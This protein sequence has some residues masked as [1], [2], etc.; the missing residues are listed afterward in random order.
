MNASEQQDKS[1]LHELAFNDED[2]RVSVAAL[3]K[4]NNFDLWWKMAEIAKDQRV[5]KHAKQK[6]EAALLGEIDIGLSESQKISFLKECNNVAL[7][8]ML[9]QKGAI[10]EANTLLML[11]VLKRINR[12]QTTLRYLNKSGNSELQ[13]A[14]FEDVREESDLNKVIK[15]A[16]NPELVEKAQ[17][18]L[19]A[20][21]AEKQKPVELNKQVKL[22]LAKLLALLDEPDF[23]KFSHQREGLAEAYD[24]LAEQFSILGQEQ[25][26][27]YNEKFQNLQQ[28]LDKKQSAL[29]EKWQVQQ[30]VERTSQALSDAKSTCRAVLDKVAEAL[31]KDASSITLG[32]LESFNQDI[33]LAEQKLNAMLSE[34]LTEQEFR[35]I[36]ALIND[37][38]QSRSS[39]DA[40][41]ALQQAISQANTM[42]EQF[43]ALPLP[44]DASQI[45]AAYEYLDEV[46]DR[47]KALS[48]QYRSIW[49]TALQSAW[50]QQ[51]AEWQ[52]TIRGLKEQVR[53]A[54]SAVRGRLNAINRAVDNGKFRHAMRSYE[55]VKVDFNNLPE[56]E[57]A[58]LTR[59]FEKVKGQIEN[60]KD[61]QAYIAQPKKPELLK[62]IEQL[63]LHPIDPQQQAE[64]VKELRKE[65]NS[66]GDVDTEADE[67]M[68]K[69]FNLA[70]EEAFKP[71]REYYAELEAQRE[72]NLKEKHSLLDTLAAASRDDAKQ[73]AL[74][75][76]EMQQ[77]W[78]AVGGVD[79]KVLDALN[80]K[81]QSIV[82]PIKDTV[83]QYYQDNAEKKRE[84][85]EKAKQLLDLEDW[86]DATNQAKALQERWRKL[87]FAGQK[88]ENKL[89]AEFR[90]INDKIFAKREQAMQEQAQQDQS[91]ID[92]VLSTIT[93]HLDTLRDSGIRAEL[94]TLRQ[95]VLQPALDQLQQLPKKATADT[96]TQV[97]G[98]KRQL[99][100]K[101][102]YL[103][104][105]QRSELYDNIF[106]CLAAWQ[107][108]EAPGAAAELPNFWR[109]AFHTTLESSAGVNAFDRRELTI[110]M[111]LQAN[112]PSPGSE[113]PLRKEVQLKL[114]ASKLQDGMSLDMDELLKA[115]IV[116]GPLQGQDE[117]LLQRLRAL[118]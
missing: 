102:L 42:L 67:A 112:K 18:R 46:R 63:V 69:A 108:S 98:W 3:N 94:E 35:G 2:S 109:Q 111:E 60:L 116:K 62:E 14:L 87:E 7:L 96:L 29:Q 117:A 115:W 20:I 32:E 51:V 8:D 95:D 21:E 89:W 77:K 50:Q 12:P 88:L 59:Q 83:N 36:E 101:L 57:Q 103:G 99:D 6:V 110:I 86:R 33:A 72:A 76:R 90:G 56:P 16:N 113:Q 75:L 27:T 41:P 70:C 11:A 38:M 85:L 79:Y 37:L 73:L 93:P 43:K 9:L 48:G 17:A 118:F 82:N 55:K 114:M 66:L 53:E 13:L 61:W 107:D 104:D 45:E 19:N 44:D 34:K 92:Q 49:P 106:N 4:L 65:W 64:R 58:R 81:Y 24:E 91:T 54:A 15:K 71:C 5:V 68:N 40:L 78:K 25:S 97:Q 100:E 26:D 52:K 105:S 80:E 84:L 39:L 1:L 23:D 74:D 22:I 10:D 30:E 31:E 47:W 28:R